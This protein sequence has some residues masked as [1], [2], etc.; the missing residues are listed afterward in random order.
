M[1]KY[2]MSMVVLGLSAEFKQ[3]GV[4]VNALW[5]RTSIY[6][7]AT[8]ITNKTENAW[9]HCRKE[10]ILA[11]AA[12]LLLSKPSR[13]FTGKFAIDDEVLAEGGVTDLR[14]YS[15]D[16]GNLLAIFKIK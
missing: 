4:A 10:D 7:A 14:H 6:T 12:Y 1:S 3:H 11:D 13:E 5:P 16:P 8:R 9:R 2:G 15:L